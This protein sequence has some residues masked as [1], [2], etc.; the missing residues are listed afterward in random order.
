MFAYIIKGLN[1]V[2]GQKKTTCREPWPNEMDL[3]CAV[4]SVLSGKEL[5]GFLYVDVTSFTDWNTSRDVGGGWPL[6]IPPLSNLVI[7]IIS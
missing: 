3:H 1:S 5:Q 6:L 7:W 4:S 2:R